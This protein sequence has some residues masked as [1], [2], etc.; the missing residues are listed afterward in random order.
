MPAIRIGLGDF[1]EQ[2]RRDQFSSESSDD[3]DSD[4]SCDEATPSDLEDEKKA[5]D[6][7]LQ[8]NASVLAKF[9]PASVNPKEEK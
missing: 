5:T 6:A 9:Y 2:P 4:E 3:D 1:P 8:S 7:F